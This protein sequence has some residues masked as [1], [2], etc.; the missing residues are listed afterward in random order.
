M[1]V[2]IAG[3][4]VWHF[5]SNWRYRGPPDRETRRLRFRIA[6]EVRLLISGIIVPIATAMLTGYVPNAYFLPLFLFTI[7]GLLVADMI[8]PSG[9]P[10][11]SSI[12]NTYDKNEIHRGGH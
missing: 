8:A 12:Q 5:S 1:T 11:H 10:I 7:A 3:L 6:W 9:R 4:M 2:I